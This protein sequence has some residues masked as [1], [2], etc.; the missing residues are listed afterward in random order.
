MYG[1]QGTQEVRAK[2]AQELEKMAAELGQ[3]VTL[4]GKRQPRRYVSPYAY[5]QRG[6]RL[7]C[8]MNART[9][10]LLDNMAKTDKRTK[11]SLIEELIADEYDRRCKLAGYAAQKRVSVRDLV[12][13]IVDSYC[14]LGRGVL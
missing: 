6:R 11:T 8:R 5:G 3:M 10:A 2:V 4:Y 13:A 14:G 9:V 12:K 7:E 1:A